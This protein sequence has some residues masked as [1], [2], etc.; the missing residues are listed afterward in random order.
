M[1]ITLNCYYDFVI[2]VVD[3]IAIFK[4]WMPYKPALSKK[5]Y[6]LVPSDI[7]LYALGDLDHVFL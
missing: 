2:R 5:P 7:G 6:Q 1:F 3:G 4:Y